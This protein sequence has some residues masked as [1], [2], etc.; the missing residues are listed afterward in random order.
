MNAETWQG[1]SVKVYDS[2][3]KLVLQMLVT[4]SFLTVDVSNWSPGIYVVSLVHATN[5]A[6]HQRLVID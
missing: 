4:E 5:G 6:T 1:S 3:G 2:A